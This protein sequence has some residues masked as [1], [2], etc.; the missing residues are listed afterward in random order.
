MKSELIGDRI[1][2]VEFKD[3]T[4][5]DVYFLDF[6]I[7]LSKR[8]RFIFLFTAAAAVLTVIAVLVLPSSYTAETTIL[9]PAQNSS[10]SSALMGQ[11]G[12]AGALASAAGASLG[13]KNPSDMYVSLFQ[14]RTIEDAMI[15]RFGLMAKYHAK[16][17]SQARSAFE[18]HA[19]VVLN[20]KDGIIHVTV[21]DGDPKQAAD[22]AN[23]YVDEFRKLSAHLAI[24]EASQRRVFFEQQLLESKEDLAKAE[25]ALKNT[26][27]STG[28]L[29]IDSQARSLIESAATLRAQVVAKEVQLQGM[30]SYATE[31]NP[32][33]VTA[34][35]QLAALKEQL[36]KLA[37]SDQGSSSDF[38][39]PKGKVPEAGMEYLR[40]LR[41]VKYYETISELVAK[42]YEI[43]KLDEARQGAITQV[44][45]VAVPPDHRSFPK[46]AI[47]V[48]V[49]T[50]LSFFL[51]CVWCI[52]MGRMRIRNEEPEVRQRLDALRAT[53]RK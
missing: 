37:G 49:V 9:P 19:K 13:I 1:R 27:Q 7:V 3:A 15:Q 24:T 42:Q 14:S 47:S 53:F 34:E 30:R 8:R 35:Q 2:D 32:E 33:V 20:T 10:L 18:S 39:V 51:A 41:D 25:E 21:K 6:L 17:E 48:I 44:V 46:R 26:E 52:F 11:L 38:I 4:G 16:K 28:V 12:G 50:I 29:Q 36:A 23:G 43:A 40:R 31:D 22:M 45:D 5:Q